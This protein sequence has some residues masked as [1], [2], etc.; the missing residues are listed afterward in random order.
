MKRWPGFD[1]PARLD[2]SPLL[3]DPH[4]KKTHKEGW[5]LLFFL[6]RFHGNQDVALLASLYE[7][8]WG[9]VTRSWQRLVVSSL[10][11]LRFRTSWHLVGHKIKA[12]RLVT[13]WRNVVKR[14][15]GGFFSGVV[16][17]RWGRVWR[18]FRE[19]GCRN[20]NIS[21][22]VYMLSRVLIK[23]F[24]FPV[25]DYWWLTFI[26]V[27]NGAW[28]GDLRGTRIRAVHLIAVAG[29]DFWRLKWFSTFMFIFWLK[30]WE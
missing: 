24:W 17:V 14:W 11:E 15:T 27:N 20:L 4:L 8:G 29:I 12:Q 3:R 10:K 7:A 21:W 26:P 9:A 16:W 22:K 25:L 1:P 19:D 30:V 2:C 13:Y 18:F 5:I 6:F 28:L 23:H